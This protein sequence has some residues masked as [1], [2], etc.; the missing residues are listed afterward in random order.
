M[1]HYEYLMMKI[2]ADKEDESAMLHSNFIKK[3]AACKNTNDF[4]SLANEIKLLVEQPPALRQLSNMV[5]E[6]IIIRKPQYEI[7]I[8]K[9]IK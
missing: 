3:L 8:L 4:I 7:K 6:M 1:K 9:K 2:F 5:K